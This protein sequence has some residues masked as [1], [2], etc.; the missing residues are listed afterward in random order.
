[1]GHLKES[2]HHFVEQHI[3]ADDPSPEPSWLDRQ[4]GILEPAAED[5][6]ETA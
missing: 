3:I 5:V 4:S 1:M 2:I 6:P